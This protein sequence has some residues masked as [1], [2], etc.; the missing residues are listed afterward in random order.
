MES[1]DEY[2]PGCIIR[3]LKFIEV[4]ENTQSAFFASNKYKTTMASKTTNSKL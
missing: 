4:D 1:E 2:G 3:I